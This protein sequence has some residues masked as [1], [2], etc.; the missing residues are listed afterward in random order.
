[1]ECT[2]VAP[3]RL[4]RWIP[5][6]DVRRLI[7]RHLLLIDREM[8]RRAHNSTHY[9]GY[10]SGT[11]VLELCQKGHLRLI[12]WLVTEGRM[13]WKEEYTAEAIR[14]GHA[15]ILYWHLRVD[16]KPHYYPIV[17][18]IASTNRTDLMEWFA[19]CDRRD[20]R[21]RFFWAENGHLHM[22]AAA[23]GHV[24]MLKW[25]VDNFGMTDSTYDWTFEEAMKCENTHIM[26]WLLERNREYGL[27][28]AGQFWRRLAVDSYFDDDDDDG[29]K[30]NISAIYDWLHKRAIPF[31][32]NL[33]DDPTKLLHHH[34]F[35]AV[36]WLYDHGY[37]AVEWDLAITTLV[38]EERWYI[39]NADAETFFHWFLSAGERWVTTDHCVELARHA[40]FRIL[41]WIFVANPHVIHSCATAMATALL[42]RPDL[43][44]RA[45]ID[46]MEW[47]RAN[48]IAIED[49]TNRIMCDVLDRYYESLNPYGLI[50]S[51]R[52]RIRSK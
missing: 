10:L 6:R 16:P 20:N 7:W 35:E 34:V 44:N 33:F 25:I 45:T 14:Y 24:C 9:L 50:W 3:L 4:E 13:T 46:T 51:M 41:D 15:K 1:M 28:F 18:G 22:E 26:D 52:K 19:A 39:C 37:I 21:K 11:C 49:E 40:N 32:A 23:S 36:V 29:V 43:D 8:I 42:E 48:G 5:Q 17:S 38:Q 27:Q 47:L 30:P 2:V 12:Q 31:P